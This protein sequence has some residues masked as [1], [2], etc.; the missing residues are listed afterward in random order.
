MAKLYEIKAELNTLL[1]NGF[2]MEFVNE[3]GEIDEEKVK[4]RIEELQID[5][6]E[7][8]DGIACY[9]K[10]LD[11]DAEK[12]NNEARALK[13]RATKLSVRAD[14]LRQYLLNEL[15]ANDCKKVETTRNVIALRK[16][17][18]TNIVDE[19]ALPEEYFKKE[20]KVT[21]NKAEIK[22]AIESGVEVPGAEV[23]DNFTLQLK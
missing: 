21:P 23:V 6:R 16:S 12:I 15:I 18:V 3:D 10:D 19:F 22:K 1:E 4:A 5:Y 13:E 8:L 20:V 2:T 11:A 17:R 9:I 7:K 14:S